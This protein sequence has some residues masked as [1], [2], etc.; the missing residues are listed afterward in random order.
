MLDKNPEMTTKQWV[1]EG[2]ARAFG[3]C[4]TLRDEPHGMTEEQIRKKIAEDGSGGWH[5]KELTK[6]RAEH[7]KLSVRT[8][9]QWMTAW[10]EDETR[11]V[12]S[13]KKSRRKATKLEKRHERALK[14]LQCL[15]DN[16]SISET[17]RNIAQFGV[18]QLGL[19]AYECKPYI[20]PSEPFNQYKQ[21]TLS[22]TIHDIKYHTEEKAK[23]EERVTNRLKYYDR[24][25]KDV[26]LC[27]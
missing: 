24:L 26:E 19:V 10:K 4:A 22:R 15:L 17:T 11:K 25:K 13:N 27:L 14:D 18:K 23:T 3:V 8:E 21:N 9:E 16:P 20:Q 12:Q 2:L 5:Q 7:A 6:A 1:M